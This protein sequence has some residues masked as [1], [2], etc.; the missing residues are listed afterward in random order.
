MRARTLFSMP[1]GL[2]RL[3]AA[4]AG[5]ALAL[6]ASPAHAEPAMWVVKDADSTIY[7]L[8]TFHLTKPDMHWWS[9]KIDIAFKDSDELW[10]EASPRGDEATLR[11]L[12]L[13][14][15]FDPQ[16]PLSSKLS[17]DD[18]VKVQSVA[19]DAG[20][21]AAAIEPM[22]PWL[23]GLT[24]VVA[25]L[26]KEGY[27]PKKGADRQ[28]EESAMSGNKTIKTFETPEQ[29]LLLFSSLPEQSQI[30]FLVQTLDDVAAGSE[31]VD[32]MARAWLAGDTGE[33]EAMTLNRMKTGAPELYDALFVRRNVD[34]CDQIATIMKGAG[35]S[36]VA[37]GAGHL[38]GDESVPAI[39]AKRGFTVTPY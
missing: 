31:Y 16:H 1:A 27:D 8:G 26:M 17:G 11:K 6:L 19:K 28:L 23:A 9:D 24:L 4:A 12:V 13:K 15:G 29:Q 20:V 18:W 32:G 38:V 2:G 21:P 14:H 33:L 10:L 39:L 35:T 37:V 5:A 36:F 25:P 3:I 30:A 22:R 34:W 7:L